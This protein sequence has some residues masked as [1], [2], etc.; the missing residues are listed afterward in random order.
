M[1]SAPPTHSGWR[2]GAVRRLWTAVVAALALP[3]SILATG[4]TRSRRDGPAA[5]TTGPTPGARP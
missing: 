2:R 5:W 1:H 3:L 4:T